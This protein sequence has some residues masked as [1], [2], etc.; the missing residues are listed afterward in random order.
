M[1]VVRGA[2][3]AAL[4][5]TVALIVPAVASSDTD[6]GWDALRR[7]LDLPQLAPGSSCPITPVAPEITAAYGI[8]AAT[9]QAPVYALVGSAGT[10][11]VVR[12]PQ[13]GAKW[14][15]QKVLWFANQDYTGPVL[16]RGRRLGSWEWMR[17]DRGVKP[18]A[19]IQ[20]RRGETVWWNGQPPDSRGRPSYVRA[21]APGCYAVQIDGATFTRVIVLRV[22]FARSR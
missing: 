21:R 2:V 5:A 12:A 19:E 6:P 17:F 7:P 18:A 11:G 1:A 9:G 22:E 4:V 16:I 15:G 3:A 8:G 10:V 20:W 14:R 13:W